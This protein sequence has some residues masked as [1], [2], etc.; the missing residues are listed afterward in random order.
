VE[1]ALRRRAQ[2]SPSQSLPARCCS[3][4]QVPQGLDPL[5]RSGMTERRRRLSGP[6]RDRRVMQ[7]YVILHRPGCKY[8]QL[9]GDGI[10]RRGEPVE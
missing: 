6:Y 10:G 8:L 9:M 4:W 7:C 2:L 3:H 1:L 5:G